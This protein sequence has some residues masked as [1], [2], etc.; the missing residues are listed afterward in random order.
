MP[1][2]T[3]S[4][5][6]RWRAALSNSSY[7][8]LERLLDSDRGDVI[9]AELERLVTVLAPARARRHKAR[10]LARLD[11]GD[12]YLKP[13]R[14]VDISATGARLLVPDGSDVTLATGQHLTLAVRSEDGEVH[15]LPAELVRVQGADEYGVEAGVRF[16]GT[17]A[18]DVV[19][20]GKLRHLIRTA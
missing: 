3:A 1:R 9:A 12:G 10:V 15:Y 4:V 8:E 20:D 14:V 2:A 6:P 11:T 16:L 13:V 17:S 7:P 5:P 18:G 19:A